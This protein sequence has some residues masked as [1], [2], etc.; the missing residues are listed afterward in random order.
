[1]S[2]VEIKQ[3]ANALFKQR[4]F[5]QAAELYKKVYL[6][7]QS[8]NILTNQAQ[9]E[10]LAPNDPVYPSNL[11]AALFEAG[12]YAAAFDAIIRAW[13]ALSLA[14]DPDQAL[15]LR[16]STRLVR[17]LSNGVV[18]GSLSLSQVNDEG[19]AIGRLRD[20]AEASIPRSDGNASLS[21]AGRAW[22]EWDATR[23]ELSGVQDANQQHARN[24]VARLPVLKQFYD[25]AIP[26]YYLIG[27]DHL[28][29][30][31]DD[32]GPDYPCPLDLKALPAEAL[33]N[34]AFFFGGV[35]DA[36]HVYASI[37]GLER[38]VCDLSED[39][40]STTKAHFALS[41]IHPAMLCRDLVVLMLLDMLVEGKA[42]ESDELAIKAAIHYVFSFNVVP[43]VYMQ[44]VNTVIRRLH[45]MFSASPP[46]LPSWLYVSSDAAVDLVKILD[47]WNPLRSHQTA[48]NI[49]TVSRHQ[50]SMPERHAS[51]PSEEGLACTKQMIF[52]ACA[53]R[54]ED[55]ATSL[56]S[57]RDRAGSSAT[58]QQITEDLWYY[59]TETLVPPKALRDDLPAITRL[60][61]YVSASRPARLSR[62][63]ALR[64]VSDVFSETYENYEANPTFFDP[65]STRN[66][67]LSFGGWT[68]IEGKDYLRDTIRYVEVFNKRFDLPS[69]TVCAGD[70]EAAAFG[71]SSTFF[72]A[73]VKSWRAMRDTLTF[74]VVLGDMNQQLAVMRSPGLNR[75]TALPTKFTRMWLSNVPDYTHGLMNQI[76]FALPSLQSHP[77][78]EIAS[79][80]LLH[81][82]SF[83]GRKD[84]Y[85]HTYTL[86][87]PQEVTSYLNCR[88]DEL[89]AQGRERIGW[90]S[91]DLKNASLPP[92]EDVSRWLTRV[93]VNILWPGDLSLLDPIYGSNGIRHTMN[94]NAFVALLLHLSE[95]GY[96]SHWLSD[97]TNSLLSNQHMSTVELYAGPL[98]IPA[99][100]SSR[101]VPNR[102]LWL[103]PW[104]TELS[105]ILSL[106][107]P[108]IPFPIRDISYTDAIAL[109]EADPQIDYPALNGLYSV[110]RQSTA[111]NIHFMILHPELLPQH[112][113]LILDV[114]RI[115]DGSGSHPAAEKLAIIT[116]PD[117]VSTSDSLAQWRLRVKDYARMKEE[118]WSLVMYRFDT[119]APV[120]NLMSA[121]SWRKLRIIRPTIVAESSVP[122]EGRPPLA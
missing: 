19:D 62:S 103:A 119:N 120:G 31:V 65:I 57:A 9:A 39:L 7:I 82:Y 6:S 113:Q 98:P 29:S 73:V 50:P 40:R 21:D 90:Q 105:T 115:L 12:D 64:M 27:H 87:K 111:P 20:L 100:Y 18:S 96:P 36:R 56:R 93:L 8:I 99:A 89:D 78:A 66:N 95:L 80:C 13:N 54:L 75:P 49:M 84:D 17:T 97:Y 51:K 81:T 47:T 35:G 108:I 60:W 121:S 55:Y 102:Q 107:A 71:V 44:W 52:F 85:C 34:L 30:I 117:V 3:E 5:K 42:S 53:S 68:N 112:R 109:F 76:I 26:E 41:D 32:Y 2:A 33:T 58:T 106:A 28:L 23:E 101:R 104:V 59:V 24:E 122:S 4:A 116:S 67:R 86:L 88:I 70:P 94:L 16:L 25:G 110:G 37:V 114:R 45:K 63:D 79:N 43:K 22:S 15:A 83:E 48:E 72:D 74:E 91:E 69:S 14:N 1:M 46:T 118:G 10:Y 77:K 38:A 92:R 61:E 11:S